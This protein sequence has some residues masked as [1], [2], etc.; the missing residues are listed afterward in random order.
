M[1]LKQLIKDRASTQRLVCV[2]DGLYIKRLNVSERDRW[3]DD[4]RSLIKQNKMRDESAV[5]LRSLLLIHTLC[6]E[7]ATNVYTID[8]YDELQTYDDQYMDGLYDQSVRLNAGLKAD[9]DDLKKN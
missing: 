5:G 1:D 4:L 3:G 2:G 9:T 7:Q 6:D 8:D